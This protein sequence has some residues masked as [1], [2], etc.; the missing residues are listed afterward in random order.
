MM[1]AMKGIMKKIRW[2][3]ALFLLF[4]FVLL[5]EQLS[6]IALLQHY[7]WLADSFLHGRLDVSRSDLTNGWVSDMIIVGKKYFWPLGPF[8]AVLLL[9]AVAVFGKSLYLSPLLQTAIVAGIVGVGFRL[10]KE[11]GHNERAAAWLSFGFV[12]ASVAV[13]CALVNTPWQIGNTLAALLFLLAALFYQKKNSPYLIGALCGAALLSRYTAGLGIIFFVA[14]EILERKPRRET[15]LRLVR[16][17]LPFGAGVLLLMLYNAA[18][19]GNPFDTGYSHHFL[20]PGPIKDSLARGVFGY[21][22]V[23]RN[24]YYYF[25]K[26]PEWYDRP[27]INYEGLSFFLISPLF[28]F[29]GFG[30][31]TKFF[32]PAVAVTV[33]A[34]VV[35]LSY[36]T[37]GFVQFGPRYLVELLPFW[38]LVLLE[39]FK[40]KGG[41][42]S[43]HLFLIGASAV[44]NLVLFIVYCRP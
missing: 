12:F 27:R 10:A 24:F 43:G 26:L 31:R 1:M 44:L 13:G 42:K 22:N 14:A 25:L 4:V 9:P 18:R 40:N 3:Q 37:T 35:Y 33:P 34:L 11:F 38:Y 39:Y 21:W 28:V 6:R 7:T 17:S 8:P 15:L 32:W 5:V 2:P 41:L 36:F 23:P 16:L 30:R 20:N 19:L 29:A